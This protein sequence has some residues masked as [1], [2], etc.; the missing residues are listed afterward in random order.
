MPYVLRAHSAPHSGSMAMVPLPSELAE[1]VNSFIQLLLSVLTTLSAAVLLG[2]DQAYC[3]RS[4]L[5]GKGSLKCHGMF[6]PRKDSR[7]RS[8]T[9]TSSRSVS[10]RRFDQVRW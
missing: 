2:R 6:V 4:K 9:S 3:T 5:P 1:S 8:P 10:L 7:C